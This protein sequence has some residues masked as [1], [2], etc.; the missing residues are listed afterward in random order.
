MVCLSWRVIPVEGQVEEANVV[1]QTRRE[2]GQAPG[3]T[4]YHAV[5]T[6]AD[7]HVGTDGE[8]PASQQPPQKQEKQAEQGGRADE[9][10]LDSGGSERHLDK[11]RTTAEKTGACLRV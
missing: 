5:S 9:H 4:V 1:L 3:G 7:A 10:S 2:L 11:N 6:A 8:N